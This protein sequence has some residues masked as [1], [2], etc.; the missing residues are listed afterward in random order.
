VQ[1][2]SLFAHFTAFYS[3]SPGA[4]V[5]LALGLLRLCLLRE[6]HQSALSSFV[7][8]CRRGGPHC[9]VAVEYSVHFI[10]LVRNIFFCFDFEKKS[11]FHLHL[12]REH[13]VCYKS[14]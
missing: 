4:A 9:A 12:E 2:F 13:I 3:R 5:T 11:Y 10:T 14:P 1:N 8:G 7:V 6:G